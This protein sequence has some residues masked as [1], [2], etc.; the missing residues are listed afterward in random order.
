MSTMDVNN[1]VQQIASELPS[2]ERADLIYYID[3]AMNNLRA[4]KMEVP[5]TVNVLGQYGSGN[6]T[7]V[8]LF[9]LLKDVK[10]TSFTNKIEQFFE[11]MVNDAVGDEERKKIDITFITVKQG[12]VNWSNKGNEAEINNAIYHTFGLHTFNYDLGSTSYRESPVLCEV[13]SDVGIKAIKTIRALL[14]IISRTTHKR[15][16]KMSVFNKSLTARI[17]NLQ[18]ALDEQGIFMAIDDTLGKNQS[19][20]ELLK[21]V[22]FSFIQLDALLDGKPVPYTKNAI[23]NTEH[24][25]M[26]PLIFGMTDFEN[27]YSPK[28]ANLDTLIAKCIDKVKER[29]IMDEDGVIKFEG[30]DNAYDIKKEAPTVCQT[31]H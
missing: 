20:S 18:T 24:Q 19:D 27:A 12:E 2:S 9:F 26:L 14:T 29:I 23:F 30:D 15:M 28:L 31:V 8:D 21:D 4:S 13:Q 6:S 22:A 1:F 16:S 25:E 7:D 10:D 17:E 3:N 11:Q 5:D